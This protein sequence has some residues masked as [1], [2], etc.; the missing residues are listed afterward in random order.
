MN[1]DMDHDMVCILFV[2]SMVLDNPLYYDHLL[3]VHTKMDGLTERRPIW[4][5]PLVPHVRP[6]PVLD[7]ELT[8]S[9][10]HVAS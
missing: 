5:I 2:H 3:L 9:K 8:L 4:L 1:I 6:K 10:E 7:G